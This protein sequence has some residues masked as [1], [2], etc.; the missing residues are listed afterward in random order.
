MQMRKRY[1]YA[2]AFTLLGLTVGG[3]FAAL[4]FVILIGMLSLFVFGAGSAPNKLDLYVGLFAW[5]VYITAI[6]TSM[7]V[8]YKLGK[9]AE[10]NFAKFNLWYILIPSLLIVSY[11]VISYIVYWPANENSRICKQMCIDHGYSGTGLSMS[12]SDD[13]NWTC[14]CWVEEKKTSEYIGNFSLE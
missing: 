10:Q 9:R 11:F 12:S 13:I 2:L 7:I 8:G 3:A 1:S 4:T 6:L 14:N 5:T